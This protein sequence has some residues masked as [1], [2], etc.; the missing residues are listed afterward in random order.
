ML[1]QWFQ[2]E[3]IFKG[4]PFAKELVARG[5]EVTVLTGF[6]NYPG[7]KLYPGYRMK[8]IQRESV[9][10][11]KI[12]R[13]PLYPSH[14]S[15]SLGRI[16]NYV[17]FALAASAI[18][19]LVIGSPDVA[20]VY[21]PPG[22]VGL[23]AIAL[24]WLRGL[25]FVYDVQDLWPDTLAASGMVRSRAVLKA[26]GLWSRLV[27]RQAERIVVLSPGFKRELIR[28]GVRDD[29]LSVI[30]NWTEDG[31]STRSPEKELA[32]KE[33]LAGR[34]SVVYAGNLGK[35]QALD[36]VV[37]AASRVQQVEPDVNFWFVGDGVEAE[38]LRSLAGAHHIESV[39]FLP[40]M[41]LDELDS[42]L[43][44]ADVLL[45]HLRDDPLFE[46]TIPSKTQAYLAAGR[47]ILMAVR[48]DAADLVVR[49]AAGVCCSP[50]D[51]ASI[52]D[53]VLRLFEMAP[54]DRA[55]MGANGRSFYTEEIQIEEGV[56]RFEECFQTAGEARKR[57]R[58]VR[59]K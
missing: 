26:V 12:I 14:G 54:S 30:Y 52:A 34:F 37:E 59:Q 46:M 28:R 23:P 31:R 36:S 21:H 5:H 41:P 4:L 11:V 51:P 44:V 43:A 13:V 29:K 58:A 15:S 18:G 55:E 25:R 48:G 47:P 35:A 2:P 45:V 9:E 27:Y 20:Y 17:S 3:P 56:S 16:L 53:G 1:T 40:R 6:P 50:E 8:L 57:R 7:G 38:R 33:A 49:A 10:G 39:H 32:W 22:T 42:L 19:P 24:R